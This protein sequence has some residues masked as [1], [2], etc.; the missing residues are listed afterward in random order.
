MIITDG[1]YGVVYNKR[2]CLAPTH[3][4]RISSPSKLRVVEVLRDGT[5]KGHTHMIGVHL[6]RAVYS[7]R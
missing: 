7:D 1:S 2:W 6:N 5:F 3:C 4:G